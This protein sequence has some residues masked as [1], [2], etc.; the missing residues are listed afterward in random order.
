M[1][2]RRATLCRLSWNR[3]NCLALLIARLKPYPVVTLPNQNKSERVAL[4]FLLK[5]SK[6]YL[7]DTIKFKY[8][9]PYNLF[10]SIRLL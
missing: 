3:R 2:F 10:Y 4:Q 5:L 6:Y 1:F 7:Q 9:S 8:Q